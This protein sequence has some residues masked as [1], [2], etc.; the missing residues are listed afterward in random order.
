MT[1]S[2]TVVLILCLSL[3]VSFYYL[4]KTGL[5]FFYTTFS[6]VVSTD[7]TKA[8]NGNIAKQSFNIH[9]QIGTYGKF[10][11]PAHVGASVFHWSRGQ[12]IFA[13]MNPFRVPRG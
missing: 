10:M 12:A 8:A 1:R 2:L 11:I 4:S 5:P 13:R 6:G 9:K 3:F 7:E